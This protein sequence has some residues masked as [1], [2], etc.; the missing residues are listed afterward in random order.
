MCARTPLSAH[1]CDVVCPGSQGW[2]IANHKADGNRWK[3]MPED[4]P[5]VRVAG[6]LTHVEQVFDGTGCA[7]FLGL[8]D[9][10]A[11]ANN[12]IATSRVAYVNGA[13]VA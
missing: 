10:E 6:F 3:H 11:V 5:F 13:A 7:I 1:V 9:R 2:W 12:P 4:E 8:E